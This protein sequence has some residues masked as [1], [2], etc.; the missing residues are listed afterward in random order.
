MFLRVQLVIICLIKN[1]EIEDG[2]II[3]KG[4]KEP[5]GLHNLRNTPCA[6]CPINHPYGEYNEII[7]KRPPSVSWVIFLSFH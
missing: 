6:I 5:H 2:E 1:S 3:N 4:S 7:T